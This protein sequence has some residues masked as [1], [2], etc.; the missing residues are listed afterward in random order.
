MLPTAQIYSVSLSKGTLNHLAKSGDNDWKLLLI[1]VQTK[2]FSQT[3]TPL[4]KS[5][6]V[7]LLWQLSNPAWTLQEK[8][9]FSFLLSFCLLSVLF[10]FFDQ[11]KWS[12][13]SF[14]SIFIHFVF[15][16]FA[17]QLPFLVCFV[18][19]WILLFFS[20]FVCRDLWNHF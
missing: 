7:W 18:V 16:P 5:H 11:G 20:T 10:L 8:G 3:V 9:F 15:F 19:L 17:F 13:C 6:V 2:S 1:K 12:S 14:I 4:P